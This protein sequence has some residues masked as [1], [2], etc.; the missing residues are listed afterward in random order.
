MRVQQERVCNA[1]SNLIKDPSHKQDTVYIFRYGTA[2]P[3]I[4]WSSRLGTYFLQ[5]AD[6]LVARLQ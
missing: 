5:M 6:W 4:C 2:L 3:S 1:I